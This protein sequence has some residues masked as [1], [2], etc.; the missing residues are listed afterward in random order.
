MIPLIKNK[1]YFFFHFTIVFRGV[2]QTLVEKHFPAPDRNRINRLLGLDLPQHTLKIKQ[3]EDYEVP[4]F[5][6]AGSSTVSGSNKRKPV[7]QAAQRAT[8]KVNN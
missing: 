2:L 6:N 5:D 3:D 4:Q 1:T 8:K 7:R